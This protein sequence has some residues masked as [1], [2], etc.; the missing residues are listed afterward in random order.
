MIWQD[1]R[2]PPRA[3]IRGGIGAVL[4]LKSSLYTGTMAQSEVCTESVPRR[5]QETGVD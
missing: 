4:L 2:I 1:F 5:M 3:F